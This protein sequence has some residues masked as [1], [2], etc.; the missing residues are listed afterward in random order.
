MN[1]A[2]AM[3]ASAASRALFAAQAGRRDGAAEAALSTSAHIGS[4]K[5]KARATAKD[6]EAV[7]LS[8]MFQQMFSG[9][10]TE[11][12][13]G[14]GYGEEVFREMLAD[15]YAREVSASGGIGLADE[16]YR[17]ILAIQ[18]GQNQ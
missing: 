17:E 3:P 2:G 6:F 9:L 12:P 7:F 10:K 5:E 16:V 11:A 4:A 18:E 14:G 15:E 13:F 1:P 8:T